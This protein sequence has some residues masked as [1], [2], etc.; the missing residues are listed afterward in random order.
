LGQ[1][2]GNFD[3]ILVP[4]LNMGQLRLLIRARFLRDVAG[5]NK[6]KGKPFA[7]SDIVDKIRELL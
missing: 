4:E 1:I 2:L 3:K 5:L 7:V 6:V